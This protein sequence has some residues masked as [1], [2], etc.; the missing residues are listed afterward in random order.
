M[1]NDQWVDMF[2]RT[3]VEYFNFIK[4]NLNMVDFTNGMSLCMWE[5]DFRVIR[6]TYYLI[7]ESIRPKKTSFVHCFSGKV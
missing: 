5:Y 2:T 3:P 6:H 4:E 7:T 1:T